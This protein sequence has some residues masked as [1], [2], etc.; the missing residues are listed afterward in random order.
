MLFG[1]FVIA[2][3]F[4]VRG[5]VPVQDASFYGIASYYAFVWFVPYAVDRLLVPVEHGVEM[6]LVFPAAAV[7]AEYAHGLMFG[8]WTSVAYTQS[9]SLPLLQM[10]SVTGLWGVTFLVMWLGPV[11]NWAWQRRWTWDALRRGL[12]LYAGIA[13]G[14]VL[15]GQARLAFAD[16]SSDTVR[17]AA[18]LGMAEMDAFQPKLEQA[19]GELEAQLSIDYFES[20]LEKGR[21]EA[22]SGAQILVWPELIGRLPARAESE[23]LAR[24][25]NFARSEGVHLLVGYF[26]YPPDFPSTFGR[27]KAVL[28]TPDGKVG[29]DYVKSSVVPG[30]KEIPGDWRLPAYESDV[31]K[32][33]TAICYDM[34]FPHFIRQAGVRD[35]ALMLVPAWD[36]AGIN[37]LHTNMAVYRAIE[38]G[39]SLVRATARGTSIAVDAY[40]RVLARMDELGSQEDIMVAHVP[41]RSIKTLYSVTGDLFAWICGAL[42]ALL[43]VA[44]VRA[45]RREKASDDAV[46]R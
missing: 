6:T 37:P 30:M 17:V 1:L 27:N 13:L 8:T 22:E 39:F 43:A 41:V 21:K 24:A 31:G 34:D 25:G 4:M 28:L 2:A 32:L 16:A 3:T 46:T 40:G 12:G 9:G 29:W 11:V 36:W 18:V 38:N 19:K 10:V 20:L 26:V 42:V 45:R 5:I 14:I 44:A 7:V 15:G 33:G 35:V 23:A